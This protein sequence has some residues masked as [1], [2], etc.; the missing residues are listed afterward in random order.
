MVSTTIPESQLFRVLVV[1]DEEALRV[2]LVSFLRDRGMAVQE[3]A[4]GLEALDCL[5]KE[6]CDA[7]V[8]DIRM[9]GLDGIGLLKA[10][11]ERYTGIEVI[12]VT[13]FQ[14]META[15][16][17]TRHSAFDYL[18]KPYNLGELFHTLHR[19]REGQLL[20]QQL[21]HKQEQLHRSQ[22]MAS[23][24][25]LTAGIMHEINNPNTF[26][27]GNAQFLHDEVLPKL[28]D[29]QHAALL[30]EATGL[31][32]A[33]LV[34]IVDAM[35][36]GSNRITEIIRR[37]TNFH[38]RRGSGRPL[39]DLAFAARTAA[40]RLRPG[41]PANVTL[42][43]TLPDAPVLSHMDEEEALQL[44]TILLTNGMEAV[45]KGGGTVTLALTVENGTARYAV[46]DDG[47]G[48]DPKKRESIFDPF[49]TTKFDRPGRGLG[50]YI[51][52]QIA[53]GCGGTLRHEPRDP[54]G[55]VFSVV[56]PRA[57]QSSEAA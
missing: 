36:N 42:Q 13:G 18:A 52:T 48:V 23:L 9:P 39:L 15:I 37:C 30:Q 53:E 19:I 51:A 41:L 47:P 27:L 3:A 5:E 49:T 26:I 25:A 55:A 16:A 40:E 43:T 45:A 32:H 31:S 34:K 10:V 14:D 21:A 33:E 29:P 35:I 12:L 22:R 38:N 8:S 2:S 24:G 17:A 50:L 28:A 11:R 6:P 54:H 57:K 7:V 56:L 20:R 44:L 1:D 4:S 46:S